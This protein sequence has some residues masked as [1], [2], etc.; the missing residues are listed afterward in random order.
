MTAAFLLCLLAVDVTVTAAS[1]V[2]L[3]CLFILLIYRIK[4]GGPWI[5][6]VWTC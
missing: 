6:V 5:N 2:L 3:V 1:A 4:E